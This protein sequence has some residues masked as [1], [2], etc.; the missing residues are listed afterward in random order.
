MSVAA[1]VAVPSGGAAASALVRALAAK[2]R[3]KDERVAAAALALALALDPYP[4]VPDAVLPEAASAPPEG[5]FAAL[6][7]LRRAPRQ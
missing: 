2:C 1:M 7:A 3:D 5:A 4:R 6:A